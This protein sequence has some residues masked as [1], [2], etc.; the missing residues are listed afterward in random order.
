MIIYYI[1]FL[2]LLLYTIRDFKKSFLI[3][4]ALKIILHSGICLKYT[5]P[6]LTVEF[7][8]NIFYF[9]F[10]ITFKRKTYTKDNFVL[11]KPFLLI[12][13]SYTLSLLFGSLDFIPSF[14]GV[15]QVLINEYA[16]IYIL[17]HVLK[18]EDDIKFLLR[19]FIFMFLVI[20]IYGIY[21]KITQTNPVMDFEIAQFPN[22]EDVIG[23]IYLSSEERGGFLRVQSFMPIS[24]TFGAY[25]ALFVGFYLFYKQKYSSYLSNSGLLKGYILVILLILGLFFSN[26]R[27]P[28]FCF[29]VVIIPILSLRKIINIPNLIL[30]SLA[31]VIFYDYVEPYFA[32]ITSILDPE[33]RDVGGSSI[34]MRLTQISVALNYFLDSPI[35]GHGI[36]SLV[37]ISSKDADKMYGSESIWIWLFVERGLLG[38]ISYLYLFYT[39]VKKMSFSYNKKF[40]I[41]FTLGWILL[42]T[43]TTTPGLDISFY[44]VIMIILYRLEIVRQNKVKHIQNV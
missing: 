43:M 16:F 14:L 38:V 7:A 27:S 17:W 22:K 2:L 11:A 5:A 15:L 36:R 32:N 23:K 12:F 4:T 29:A 41:F 35:I 18:T 9:L 39:V 20:S 40:I 44:L 25:C 21:E 3:Y 34:E 19:N 8:A 37:Q 6:I 13:I 24:I 28:I 1:I 31:I 10:F 26:S 33:S 30:V 42:N